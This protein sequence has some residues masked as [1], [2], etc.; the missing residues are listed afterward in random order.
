[1][2]VSVI[3]LAAGQGKRM[4]SSLPK[5]LHQLAGRPLLSHVIATARQLNPEQIIVVYGHGGE[6]VPKAFSAADITWIRQELQ[7]GTGHA[8][9]QTLP[10]VKP[11]AML[12]ILSGDVPLVK[13]ETLKRLL[14]MMDQGKV[15]LLTVDLPNPNGYGRIIRDRVGKVSKI[16]EEADASPEQRQIREVNT[17]ITAIEARY[18][19]QIV[20]NLSNNNAQ[21]EYYLTDIIEYAATS[22]E[23]V[24]AVSA[25]DPIEVMGINDRQQLAYLERVY[26]KREAARLMGE[27]VTLGDP[28]R[29]D[30]RGELVAGE[31]VF[32]DI[33]VIIEGK[34]ILGDGVKIGPHCYLR[35]AVL[36]KGVEVLANCVIE[37][38]TIDARARVGPF[39]RIRPETRLGEGV[40]I[41]NFVE[42]KKSTIR[43][44]SKVNHLSYI[45]DTTIGKEVNI[46]AGT[47]TC[48]YDGASKHRTIIEDGAFVGSDTQ[49]VAP[50]KVGAGATIGA[51]TTITRDAPPGELTLS[52]APQRSSPGWKRPSK[53]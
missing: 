22:G 43:D 9:L 2:A 1:M 46:G 11:G 49:L 40:H 23:K 14:V 13:T 21:G 18:L 19:K 6:T 24:A 48:N 30:L 25:A 20:P 52:R 37:E 4:H 3:I 17:G 26:Q 15:G 51:G 8:A 45:G 33:N 7:L 16:I 10:Y 42:I 34:V 31:D 47:I 29:F 50:V 36:G 5:V 53:K 28:N 27:G 32:I 39:T 35:N 44:N 41:G 38:A 12:L